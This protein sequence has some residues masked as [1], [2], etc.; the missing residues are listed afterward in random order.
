MKKERE[1]RGGETGVV[2]EGVF[3][4][5]SGNLFVFYFILTL[6]RK[7]FWMKFQLND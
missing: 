6:R 5:R 1:R 4:Q 3:S 7:F 2:D